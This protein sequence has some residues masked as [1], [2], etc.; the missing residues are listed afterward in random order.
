MVTAQVIFKFTRSRV[1]AEVA[2][3]VVVVARLK[4][5]VPDTVDVVSVGSISDV[6]LA[7]VDQFLEMFFVLFSPGLDG[8]GIGHGWSADLW[9]SNRGE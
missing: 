8:G 2:T 5:L 1:R 3:E 6:N 4:I 7:L 9:Q